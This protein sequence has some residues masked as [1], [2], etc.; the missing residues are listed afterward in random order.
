MVSQALLIYANNTQKLNTRHSCG[1]AQMYEGILEC[2]L[3]LLT[4]AL[5]GKLYCH[6]SINT[7]THSLQQCGPLLQL[8]HSAAL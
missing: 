6:L 8:H 7:H 4:V 5:Q 2:D 3:I 1:T